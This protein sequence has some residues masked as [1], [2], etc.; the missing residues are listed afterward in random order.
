VLVPVPA[1]LFRHGGFIGPRGRLVRR[2][3]RRFARGA[4]SGFVYHRAQAALM[5]LV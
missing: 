5:P 2:D 1:Q 4:K 3:I